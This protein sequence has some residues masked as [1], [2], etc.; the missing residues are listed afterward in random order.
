MS[1]EDNLIEMIMQTEKWFENKT[2]QL[3]LLSQADKE[4]EIIVKGKSEDDSG[5]KVQPE[6]LKGFKIGIAIALEVIGEFPI[7]ITQSEKEG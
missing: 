5:V 3:K 1:K 4:T 2:N 7:K 6:D